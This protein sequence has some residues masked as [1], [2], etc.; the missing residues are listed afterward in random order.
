MSFCEISLILFIFYW[1]VSLILFFFPLYKS[2]FIFKNPLLNQ[3]LSQPK[4]LI[5]D[6]AHRGGS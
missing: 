3:L 1:L 4:K 2:K 5:L 6:V